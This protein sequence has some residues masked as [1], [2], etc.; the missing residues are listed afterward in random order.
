MPGIDASSLSLANRASQRLSGAGASSQ[1]FNTAPAW[2]NALNRTGIADNSINPWPGSEELREEDVI[3]E[4]VAENVDTL[5]L[6]IRDLRL[7]YRGCVGNLKSDSGCVELSNIFIAQDFYGSEGIIKI[8]VIFLTNKGAVRESIEYNSKVEFRTP[9]LGYI[10]YNGLAIYVTRKSDRRPESKFLRG[11]NKTTLA[12]ILTNE[13]ELDTLRIDKPFSFS[14]RGHELISNNRYKE[15]SVEDLHR[16]LFTLYMILCNF[17]DRIYYD[18][19]SGDK[20]LKSCEYLSFA[21]SSK[22]CASINN[23][24]NAI[25]LYRGVF[26]IGVYSRNNNIWYTITSFFNDELDALG[27]KYINSEGN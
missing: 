22:Y 1:T 3:A 21:Y 6:R 26:P 25:I 14:Q 8:D 7:R 20:L 9:R 27:I 4:A 5:E 16:E 23:L 24:K 19:V 15:V 18:S 11:F 12:V 13:R 10:N 17:K 2:M